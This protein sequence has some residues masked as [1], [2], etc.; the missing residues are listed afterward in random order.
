MLN[1]FGESRAE[2]FFSFS[3][4]CSKP[5]S[6]WI[7]RDK[8]FP[9]PLDVV[10]PF[11]PWPHEMYKLLVAQ[12]LQIYGRLSGDIGRNPCHR[13]VSLVHFRLGNRYFVWS[14]KTFR[15]KSLSGFV[16]PTKSANPVTRIR[17]FPSGQN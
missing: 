2:I 1:R 10:Q 8:S 15:M 13:G 6:A 7:T 5:K 4:K 16:S 12:S 11:E 14:T 9:V 17:S 3:V